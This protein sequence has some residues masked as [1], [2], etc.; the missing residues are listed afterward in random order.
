MAA[1]EQLYD[2][3]DFVRMYIWAGSDFVPGCPGLSA[4][5]CMKLFMQ[6][7]QISPRQVISAAIVGGKKGAKLQAR[8]K[9]YDIDS[10]EQRTDWCLDYWLYSLCG[11][12]QKNMLY[13][14]PIGHG[15]SL[16]DGRIVYT[17]DVAN[18]QLQPSRK[19]TKM[20]GLDVSQ[21]ALL[22]CRENSTHAMSRMPFGH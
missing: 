6:Q 17:E 15:F 22:D 21:T 1:I 7:P 16:Q 4:E 2:V 3:C 12:E 13:L 14:T 18:T 10:S 5:R 20:S 9:Q 19:R 8:L 11:E